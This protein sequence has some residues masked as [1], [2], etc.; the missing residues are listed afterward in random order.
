MKLKK[1]G[2]LLLMCLFTLQIPT[3]VMAEQ[4]A[5]NTKVD[6]YEYGGKKIELEN[7][8]FEK[9]GVVYV[10]LREMIEKEGGTI[11]YNQ[12][13]IEIA[14][15]SFSPYTIRMTLGQKTYFYNKHESFFDHS[16]PILDG[17]TYISIDDYNKIQ[18]YFYNIEYETGL[19]GEIRVLM[20]C[21]E[22]SYE[23]KFGNQNDYSFELNLL[24][25]LPNDQNTIISPDSLKNV[26]AMTANG[27]GGETQQQILSV[28]HIKDLSAFNQ[29]ASN[30]PKGSYKTVQ[31][32]SSNSIWVNNQFWPEEEFFWNS[33]FSKIVKG[34]YQGSLENIDGPSDIQKLN[35]WISDNTNG[36]ITNLV[37]DTKFELML[38]NASS[39]SGQWLYPFYEKKTHPN[40]FTTQDGSMV[41]TDFME[42]KQVSG[43]Y[44][45]DG[46]QA[47]SLSYGNGYRELPPYDM[48]FILTEKELNSEILNRIFKYQDELEVS[49]KIPKFEVENQTDYIQILKNIGIQ[50]L[51]DSSKAD[52]TPMVDKKGYYVD[53]IFQNAKIAI[54][55]EGTLASAATA[56]SGT[57]GILD[58][59]PPEFVADHPFYYI[60]RNK[61]TGDI[62]F[63]GYYGFV[64]R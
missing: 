31:W 50:D 52:L 24:H 29:M 16:L 42:G 34:S 53:K 62:L 18:C 56:L 40:P 63:E 49:V 36:G 30:R 41:I 7:S 6:I 32:T 23:Q 27:T 28:L 25:Q 10:P 59:L 3:F 38:L 54:D 39:F 44:E 22:R 20:R 15:G 33:N 51:F 9:N 17:T 12:P 43:Y 1:I 19:D 8:C 58:K 46:V 55:E 48:T 35:T 57:R 26:L 47:L 5:K 4:E 14:I 45:E 21:K 11:T 64:N 60:I 13:N 61:E 2:F 37:T